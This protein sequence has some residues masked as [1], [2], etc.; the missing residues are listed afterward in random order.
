MLYNFNATKP[1]EPKQ[2]L[3]AQMQAAVSVEEGIQW[4]LSASTSLT[5]TESMIVLYDGRLDRTI[6]F[7][8]GFFSGQSLS[9]SQMQAMKDPSGSMLF[10]QPIFLAYG[11]QVMACGKKVRYSLANGCVAVPASAKQ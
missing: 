6:N 8:T 3:M 5:P 2:A 10:M 11:S 1:H 4:R 7:T 9:V